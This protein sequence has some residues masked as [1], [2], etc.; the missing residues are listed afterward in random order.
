ME[1]FYNKEVIVKLSVILV[2]I[3]SLLTIIFVLS[4]SL[5]KES[6]IALFRCLIQLFLLSQVLIYLFYYSHDSIKF[7]ACLFIILMAILNTSLKSDFKFTTRDYLIY[8]IIYLTIAPFLANF[9][10]SLMKDQFEFK[11]FIP[12][13]GMILG[14][15]L[16]GIVLSR[17]AF[18]T[19]IRSNQELI[20][21]KRIMGATPYESV[22]LYF[23][24]AIRTGLTPMLN[25]L[26]I[27]G[28]VS[29]PGMLTGQLIANEDVM[30]AVLNQFIIMAVIFA[31]IYFVTCIGLYFSFSFNLGRGDL[32]DIY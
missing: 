10:N 6:A 7:M 21:L 13:L 19:N 12:I 14:N 30:T 8:S 22:R 5:M 24:Q 20:S 1:F 3:L 23:Q 17:N 16:N 18:F 32:H 29:L 28:I 15:S 27:V 11:F 2:F 31:S 25:V 26:S 9:A 4:R